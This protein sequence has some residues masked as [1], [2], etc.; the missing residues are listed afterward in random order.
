MIRHADRVSVPVI[1]HRSCSRTLY[2]GGGRANP[3]GL[4]SARSPT[5]SKCRGDCAGKDSDLSR[6]TSPCR[7]RSLSVRVFEQEVA[8]FFSLWCIAT[9][10]L[11][12][13]I[14]LPASCSCT[15]RLTKHV[16]GIVLPVT[17]K[18][19]HLFTATDRGNG[20]NLYLQ[21]K[22]GAYSSF[23][24]PHHGARRSNALRAAMMHS[25][26]SHGTR[27]RAWRTCWI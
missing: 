4:P 13:S 14:S 25:K 26:H 16:H 12:L 2:L 10:S 22:V 6:V 7:A 23:S 18:Y 15:A 1:A 27:V 21:S 5:D 19:D 9:P 20:G 24:C 8:V 3:G 11:V 17:Q